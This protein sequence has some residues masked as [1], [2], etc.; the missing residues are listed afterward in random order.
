LLR[1]PWADAVPPRGK[2][3][4]PWGCNR[5]AYLEPFRKTNSGIIQEDEFWNRSGKRIL[6][7]VQGFAVGP[8]CAPPDAPVSRAGRG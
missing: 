7:P 1:K 3:R 8:D 5:R 4:P 2:Y 6:K